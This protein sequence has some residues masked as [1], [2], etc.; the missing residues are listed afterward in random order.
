MGGETIRRPVLRKSLPPWVTAVGIAVVTTGLIVAAFPASIWDQDEAYFAAAVLR[1]DPSNLQPHPPFFPL[2]I[3]IGKLGHRLLPN[4]RPTLGLQLASALAAVLLPVVLFELFSRI[5]DRRQALAAALLY[6]VSP[7]P[8]L[9][10]GRAYTEPAA[11]LL[12]LTG[13]L[14]LL[15]DRRPVPLVAAGSLALAAAFLVRPQWIPIAGVICLWTLVRTHGLQRVLPLV[16]SLAAGLLAIAVMAHATGGLDPLVE[17]VRQHAQ[18]Q[19][20][21][22]ERFRFSLSDIALVPAC[23]GRLAAASWALLATIGAVLLIRRGN[24]FSRRFLGLVLLP[25]V[26]LFLAAQ[27]PTLPRY[28]IPL[29]A[30]TAGLV[31]AGLTLLLGS[32]RRGTW[33]ALAAVVL[34]A[35]PVLPHLGTYREMPSP[36]IRLLHRL[37]APELAHTLLVADHR[38]API[39]TYGRAEARLQ[40]RVIWDWAVQLGTFSSPPR[41]DLLAVWEGTLPVWIA[42]GRVERFGT[43]DRFLARTVSPRFTDLALCTGCAVGPAPPHQ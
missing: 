33:A 35:L 2:W 12:L 3:A 7:G 5:G 8:W 22:L 23:G 28:A 14:L 32:P 26:F 17:A 11:T 39:L 38:L 10:A 29:L 31:V 42:G 13:A 24:S 16:V 20:Q 37:E 40:Q 36:A 18:Y 34:I 41:D 27:N 30:E 43:G 19:A 15:G 1:F 21:T 25:Q 6:A 4:A 9:L